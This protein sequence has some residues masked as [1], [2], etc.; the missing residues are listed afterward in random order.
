MQAFHTHG[1]LQSFIT[2]LEIEIEQCR[3]DQLYEFKVHEAMEG[4]PS[5]PSQ[6]LPAF[7]FTYHANNV[8]K[9]CLPQRAA[10]LKSM[11]N[12]MKKA[13]QDPT[14]AESIRHLMEGTLPSSLKHIIL[15][16]EYYGPSLFLLATD[17]VTV[18]VFQV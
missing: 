8:G 9:S 12:F 2:R 1:G 18:Y 7:D 14:F 6:E 10:L 11:L 16:A 4:G 17:V 5:E 3:R 13:L 15:N